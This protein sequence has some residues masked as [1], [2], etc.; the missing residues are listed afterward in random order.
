MP[1]DGQPAPPA[2]LR[3]VR[4]RLAELPGKRKLDLLLEAPDPVALVQAVPEQELYQAILEIGPADSGEILS[5]AAPEQFVHFIDR[6]AWP[7]SWGN[8][9]S[10]EVLRWLTLARESAGHSDQA[11]ARY[12]DKLASLDVEL[13]ELVLREELRVHELEE[14]KEPP[15]VHFDRT[16]RTPEG[17]YLI[18]F[19]ADG[20][21][22]G[23]LKQLLDDLF[24]QD[25][26]G[27][28]RLLE[29][30]RWEL[31]SDL[32]E[33]ARRWRDG[34]LRD[35]GFPT[36]EEAVSFYARPN[37]RASVDATENA[38]PSTALA[39]VEGPLLDRALSLVAADDWPRVEEAL[40]YAS[41]AALVA[42]GVAADDALGAKLAL[43][44]ARATL[45]LGLELI[46]NGDAA[47]AAKLLAERPVREIFQAGMGELYR[48]QS[49]ARKIGQQ[50]A[51]PGAKAP[52][53]IE[54][55]WS[56]ML[57][58][59]QRKRPALPDERGRGRTHIP[60][61]RAEIARADATLDEAAA[62][63]PLLETLGIGPAALAPL[64]EQA[65]LAASAVRASDAVRALARA[66]LQGLQGVSFAEE[67]GPS[68]DAVDQKANELL[69]SAAKLVGTDAA[70][71]AAQK[72]LHKG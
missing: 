68:A 51:L 15:V 29:A 63:V 62:L 41:N 16:Y 50:A 32:A 45:S 46:A 21:D 59:L 12:R 56:E 47:L 54:R 53:L 24:A 52:T 25:T 71:R 19:A 60:A 65:G 44:G 67:G 9:T 38:T 55:P 39:T 5:L 2:D 26:L 28:I 1:T 42:N 43:D 27:T 8:P 7:E 66:A 36:L 22:Y 31:P 17:K 57:E 40:V 58:S 14:G 69:T 70:A 18:E 20:A 64:A 23:T 6:A 72:L 11:L 61:T 4:R 30:V 10:R 33:T 48:L 37:R 34:R 13:L 3:E 49:R 35:L